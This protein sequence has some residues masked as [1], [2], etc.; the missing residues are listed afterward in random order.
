MQHDLAPEDFSLPVDQQQVISP[1]QVRDVQR[2]FIAADFARK[3]LGLVQLPFEIIE[4]DAE[5]RCTVRVQFQVQYFPGWHWSHSAQGQ[6]SGKR[7]SYCADFGRR[8][9][10][11]PIDLHD[12]VM[13]RAQNR[14][15]IEIFVV[16]T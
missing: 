6:A 3:N 1:L 5:C 14:A 2:P 16:G 11:F 12:A 7:D 13:V 10:T 15:A 9:A 8:L 4:L